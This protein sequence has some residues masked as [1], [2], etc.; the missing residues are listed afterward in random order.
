MQERTELAK[1]AMF[2]CILMQF[3]I[4]LNASSYDN[5]TYSSS[6]SLSNLSVSHAIVSPNSVIAIM[7]TVANLGKLSSSPINV[8][9]NVSGP[10]DMHYE[11][12]LGRLYPMQY[13][14]ITAVLTNAA[15]ESG[16]YGIRITAYY[17]SNGT[18]E[19]SVPLQSNYTVSGSS[20]PAAIQAPGNSVPWLIINSMPLYVVSTGGTDEISS[21]EFTNSGNLPETLHISIPNSSSS[22]ASIGSAKL[23]L[24]P[25]ESLGTDILLGPTYE[26]MLNE[27]YI[28]PVTIEVTYQN[29]TELNSTHTIVFAS[30]GLKNRPSVTEYYSILNSSLVSGQVSIINKA[31]ASIASLYLQTNIPGAVAASPDNIAT[32]GINYSLSSNN[33]SYSINWHSGQIAPY[34]SA[35]AYFS[36]SNA[37]DLHLLSYSPLIF[38]TVSSVSKYQVFDVQKIGTVTL[39]PNSTGIINVSVLYTGTSPQNVSMSVSAPTSLKMLDPS[40]SYAASPNQLATRRFGISTGSTIGTFTLAIYLS[41]AGYNSSYSVPVIVLP[42][43]ALATVP[44]KHSSSTGAPA[45]IFPAF[46]ALTIS[47][48]F[49]ASLILVA[50]RRSANRFRMSRLE[51]LRRIKRMFAENNR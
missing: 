32:S 30:L 12:A 41:S 37:S 18:L 24:R 5:A 33:G 15:Y 2:A 47:F 25:H 20:Q 51:K 3:A 35:Y 48:I 50:R 31:N 22:D 27:S 44:A 19:R 26:P 6:I 43:Q 7:F 45:A 14:N 17:Y 34:G 8:S 23:Y 38:S 13:S 49:I 46:A 4:V 16:R 1:F 28:I 29:G 21:M 42:A 39:V 9:I 36:I 10:Q 11:Y 40:Q